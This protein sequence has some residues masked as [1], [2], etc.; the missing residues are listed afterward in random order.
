[1]TKTAVAPRLAQGQTKETVLGVLNQMSKELANG[2]NYKQVTCLLAEC[3]AEVFDK[4][5][6][7][8]REVEFE[9]KTY[10]AS[11]GRGA[12]EDGDVFSLWIVEAKQTIPAGKNGDISW[13]EIPA[14]AKRLRL[15]PVE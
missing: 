14:G 3:E 13:A 2:G 4:K 1:M 6:P 9:G 8:V 5:M 15:F 7:R 10:R 11:L 12:D